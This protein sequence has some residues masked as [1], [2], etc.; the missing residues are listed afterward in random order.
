VVR[1]PFNGRTRPLNPHHQDPPERREDEGRIR[2]F[3]V[4]VGTY[5]KPQALGR[6]LDSIAAQRFADVEVVVVRDGRVAPAAYAAAAAAA[7]QRLG[8]RLHWCEIG[9]RAQG[10]GPSLT[11]NVAATLARGTYLAFLDDDD[12]WIDDRHLGDVA[13]VLE[14]HPATDMVFANQETAGGDTRPAT[15]LW[16]NALAD[17][18]P[19]DGAPTRAV[20]VDRALVL[21]VGGFPH[22]NTLVVKRSLFEAVN[23]F[24]EQ[25]RY[26]EDRDL[27]LRLLDRAEHVVY[28]PRVVAR[29]HVPT[30]GDPTSASAA[31]GEIAKLLDRLRLYDKARLWASCPS[32]RRE[33]RRRKGETLKTLAM[34]LHADGRH[35]AAWRYALEGAALKP[36]V[37]WAAFTLYL[38]ARGV[39]ARLPA[40]SLRRAPHPRR[41]A[42]RTSPSRSS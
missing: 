42:R 8:D 26:E 22:L 32:M 6:A 37:K 25:L 19:T 40:G 20:P 21:E 18:V 1:K 3:S 12:V 30:A 4:I 34:V 31:L 39:V 15:R 9:C 35:A 17:R 28:M 36:T 14:E 11:R 16:L 13:A 7:R 2:M 23:G 5:A 29:H 33:G 41:P 10:A 24:D 27:F 38:M